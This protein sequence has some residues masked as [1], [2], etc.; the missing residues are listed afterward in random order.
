MATFA[1][2]E[3]GIVENIAVADEKIILELIMP[4]KIILEETKSTG[5]AWIGSEVINGKFKPPQNYPSWSFND[6]K[7]IWQAPTPMPTDGKLYDWIESELN[8]VEIPIPQSS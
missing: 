3:N 7:F 1:V 4:E 5:I 2:I 6:S 8:W